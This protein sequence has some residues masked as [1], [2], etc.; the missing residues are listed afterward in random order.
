MKG[1]G[2]PL[3][4][5]L[6][7]LAALLASSAGAAART[8]QAAA[9][10]AA[11]AIRRL[12]LQTDLPR[13]KEPLSWN[14]R[15][16]LPRE[17][18]WGAVILAG[19]LLLYFF[20]KDVLPGLLPVRR[21]AWADGEG[22]AAAGTEVASEAAALAAEDLARQGRFVEA[23]HVLLLQSLA[24]IRRR[25]G[26]SFAQSQTSREILRSVRL[27]ETGRAALRDIVARVER[28]YFG[29]HPAGAAEYRSC[30]D[31]FDLLT[32]ALDGDA[33]A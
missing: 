18:F 23:M 31:S 4:A 5:S 3:A 32:A 2:R 15:I 9:D 6:L 22:V 19:V 8:A 30:R 12:D 11:E 27:S 17:L 7:P 14:W 10:I 29:D 33:R 24:E 13:Q 25:R 20:V 26:E 28:S 21:G 16:P 1:M